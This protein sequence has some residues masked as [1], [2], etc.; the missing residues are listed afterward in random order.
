MSRYTIIWIKRL[1][2]LADKQYSRD[3]KTSKPLGSC[4]RASFLRLFLGIMIIGMSNSPS[5]ADNGI[6]VP[7]TAK[8]SFT[9]TV[10]SDT[11]TVTIQN[12]SSD[13]VR[14]LFMSDF[15]NS[16]VVNIDCMVDNISRGNLIVER[17]FG[18]VY[19]GKYSTR[20]I[21]GNFYQTVYL[22]FYSLQ[23]TSNELSLS[24]GHRY[25]IFGTMSVNASIG[26]PRDLHWGQ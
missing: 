17:E 9:R 26:P 6:P 12:L 11:V 18:S 23:Y 21:I 20:W 16:Q 3:F 2:I 25:S 13:S 1:K 8:V 15:T 10:S 14:N 5:F 7:D 19:P 22:R 24:A 4:P